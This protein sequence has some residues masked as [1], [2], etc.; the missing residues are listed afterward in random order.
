MDNDIAICWFRKD[1]RIFDNPAL[2][3][4]CKHKKVL[5]I[6]I[7][8]DV[9][10]KEYFIG[11]AASWWLHNSL[12]SLNK[13]LDDNLS[14]YRG[15]AVDILDDII[16]RFKVKAVY[17]NRCYEPWRIKRDKKIKQRLK[18]KNIKVS[19]SN[20]SLL[21]EPWEIKKADNTPYKVFTPFYKKGCLMAVEPRK[22]TTNIN[23]A[24][25]LKDKKEA[26]EIDK[27]D[28]LSDNNW[29]KDFH[30][31]WKVGE[32]ASKQ[33]LEK[34]LEKAIYNYKEG[35]NF[36]AKD[37]VSRLSAH[38]SFGEI[39]VNQ[40]WYAAK[41]KEDI[42]NVGH[43]CS[44]L[45]WREFSYSQLY[46]NENLATQNLQ[47]KFDNFPWSV[48]LTFLRAWKKG[49][50]GVPIVDAGMR[51][52]WQTG[53]MHNR[54]RMIAASF[55]VKNLLIDWRY[56]ERWFWDTLVDADLAN[57]SA[58]WQWVAGCGADAAPYFR[59]FNPVTQ[60]QRFDAEGD[61]IRKF[62]PEISLLPNKYL[63]NP[64]EA[65]QE[66]LA[67]SKIELG[68]TYPKPLIDLKKSRDEALIAFKLL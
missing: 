63:F 31:Y 4:A 17:W 55:L 62:V 48:D 29:H 24:C 60:A 45:A 34:F 23:K 57:N 11:E 32:E 3:A 6:Y 28:I 30:K 43:F 41:E 38:L 47:K 19:S 37:C 58:S 15:D 14:C 27:L 5:P 65:P 25:Y 35:R 18:E 16:E 39:S 8:D 49:L 46:Y 10:A 36:P 50:T 64:W 21:W 54:V 12:K 67:E 7:V 42:K 61:Y 40:V 26:T 1:L 44:E 59:I 66:I 2:N 68:K 56:G 20:G 51:E 13:S 33:C 22:P 52:L 9:N 53:Y